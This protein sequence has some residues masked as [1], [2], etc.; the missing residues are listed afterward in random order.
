MFGAPNMKTTLRSDIGYENHYS[1]NGA[2][3]MLQRSRPLCGGTPR[4]AGP[5]KLCPCNSDQLK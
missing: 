3:P 4:Q 5:C 2:I 1:S